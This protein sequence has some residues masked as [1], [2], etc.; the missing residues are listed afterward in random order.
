MKKNELVSALREKFPIFSQTNDEDD[1]YLLYGSFGSFFIDLINFHFLSG[2][3]PRNYFYSNVDVI[4]KD[5][6]FIGNEIEMI[7]LFIDELYLFSD[8][9]VRDILNTCVFEAMMGNDFSAN[10]ARKFLSKET[11]DHYLSISKIVT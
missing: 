3:E 7:Y 11:Y 8:N 5:A 6:E 10:L 1:V 2:C 4:Y 9:G